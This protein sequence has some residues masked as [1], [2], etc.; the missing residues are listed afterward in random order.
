M[1]LMQHR[2]PLQLTHVKELDLAPITHKWD[3][4]SQL[5]WL[6]VLLLGHRRRNG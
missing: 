5:T 2:G 3:R 4:K 1:T 6:G